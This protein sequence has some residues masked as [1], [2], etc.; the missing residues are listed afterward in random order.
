MNPHARYTIK[1]PLQAENRI[2]EKDVSLCTRIHICRLVQMPF[3]RSM[4]NTTHYIHTQ[5]HPNAKAKQFNSFFFFVSLWFRLNGAMPSRNLY[6]DATNAI[7]SMIRF[8][9]FHSFRSSTSNTC[10]CRDVVVCK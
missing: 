7:S 2:K 6:N 9:G 8:Y 10:I 4:C 1:N 3:C 5:T